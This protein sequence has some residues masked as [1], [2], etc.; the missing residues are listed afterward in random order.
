MIQ[1]YR[2]AWFVVAAAMLVMPQSGAIA[3]K[4]PWDVTRYSDC[5]SHVGTD[6]LAP[7]LV[8][9]S[10][11]CRTDR[12][13]VE[14]KETIP[15]DTKARAWVTGSRNKDNPSNAFIAIIFGTKVDRTSTYISG[16]TITQDTGGALKYRSVITLVGG[17]RRALDAKFLPISSGDCSFSSGGAISVRKCSYVEGAMILI[18]SDL[19]SELQTRNFSETDGMLRFRL[20]CDAGAFTVVVPLA[21]IEA[22][23]R[24]VFAI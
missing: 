13:P 5:L 16:N 3:K 2:L 6:Q 21:E 17:S 22:V 4:R 24:E 7:D 1:R 8:I 10:E 9:S 20:E 19:L 18:P 11:N 14:A 12:N 15:S 23:R